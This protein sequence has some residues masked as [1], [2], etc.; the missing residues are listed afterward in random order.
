M[1]EPKQPQLFIDMPRLYG[2]LP[3]YHY[4]HCFLMQR[5]HPRTTISRSP[6]YDQ[7]LAKPMTTMEEGK[8][9]KWLDKEKTVDAEK[10]AATLTRH[11]QTQN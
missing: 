10:V 9:T 2:M 3:Y 1:L 5:E 6:L 4:G 8:S 7:R 11:G